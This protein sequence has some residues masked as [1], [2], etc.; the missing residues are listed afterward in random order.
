MTQVRRP[1]VSIDV[2]SPIDVAQIFQSLGEYIAIHEPVLDQYGT[3]IDAHLIWWNSGYEAVRVQPV[4]Q[5]SKMSEAYFEPKI[6]IEY[7]ST[8]WSSGRAVQ[9]FEFTPAKRGQY[10]PPGPQVVISVLWERVGDYLVEVGSDLSELRQ[11]GAK[12]ADQR[13]L[14]FAAERDK[15][16]LAERERIARNLHDS[17]IQQIYASSLGLNAVATRLEDFITESGDVHD[18]LRAIVKH[19]AD[20]LSTLI[21]NI[22]DE[23]FD[24]CKEPK[25][26]LRREL[27]D[28]ILPI[29]G[30]SAMDFDMQV[31]IDELNDAD[32]VTH[33]RAVVREAVSN[34]VRHSSGS[35]VRILVHRTRDGCLHLVVADD[36]V[37]MPLGITR[38]SGLTNI[39]ERARALGGVAEILANAEGGTSISWRVPVPGWS[40]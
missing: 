2:L 33:L 24:V 23:I 37:G 14:V 38:S 1:S 34:A 35:I 4:A 5:M 19:I 39:E 30:P 21:A 27:E 3:L 10:R 11:L 40:T 17:V 25:A 7:A 13:T 28:V 8:A 6:A 12:L 9:L 26:S 29:I 36:G 20:D 18:R 16:L 22:R 32:I 31:H 15:A